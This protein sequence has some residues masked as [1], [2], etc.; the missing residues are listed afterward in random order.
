MNALKHTLPLFVLL[1][2]FWTAPSLAADVNAGEQKAGNCIG[3]HGPNGKSSSP[4]WP[5]L[6]A[7]QA[8]YI[9]NQLQAFKA[10]T[11]KNSL[12]ESTAG[13]MTDDDMKNLAAYFASRP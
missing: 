11:R 5:N 12:M 9:V 10:G 13:N 6:A 4:Q 3:C 7:Q 1:A 8:D 2:S